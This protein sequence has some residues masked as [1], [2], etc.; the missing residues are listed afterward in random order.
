MLPVPAIVRLL[1]DAGG[2]R[3]RP[4]LDASM[5]ERNEHIPRMNGR[6][7]FDVIAMDRSGKRRSYRE[8]APDE[9]Q[10]RE[11]LPGIRAISEQVVDAVYPLL[12]TFL[13]EFSSREAAF[14]RRLSPAP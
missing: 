10:L 9:T 8:V 2:F 13:Q 12:G 14:R 7:A 4:F 5:L 6:D 3:R 11:W 1:V